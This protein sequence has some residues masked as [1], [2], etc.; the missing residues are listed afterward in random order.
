M[1]RKRIFIITLL[2]VVSLISMG[3]KPRG[4]NKEKE[5]LKNIKKIGVVIQ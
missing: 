4:K 5:L 3:I 1:E 2:I